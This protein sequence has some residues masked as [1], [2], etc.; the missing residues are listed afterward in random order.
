MTPS[1]SS[2]TFFAAP[3][4]THSSGRAVVAMYW[5]PAGSWDTSRQQFL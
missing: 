3:V 2:K 4:S 1:N 5:G